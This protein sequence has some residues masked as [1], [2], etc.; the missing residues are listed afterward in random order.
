MDKTRSLTL[1]KLQ[2]SKQIAMYVSLFCD[3]EG[4]VFVKNYIGI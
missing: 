2:T 4:I 1:R 3:S